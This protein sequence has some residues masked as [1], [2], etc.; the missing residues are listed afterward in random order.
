MTNRRFKNEN[1]K[2]K[3]DIEW[4]YADF[5]RSLLRKQQGAVVDNGKSLFRESKDGY[6][7]D[8][9]II[10]LI[11]SEHRECASKSSRALM[12]SSGKIS[13]KLCSNTPVYDSFY[14]KRQTANAGKR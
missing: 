2:K 4:S 10:I 8:K 6:T 13:A 7:V 12:E 14:K 11:C 3:S 1:N 9:H 5:V